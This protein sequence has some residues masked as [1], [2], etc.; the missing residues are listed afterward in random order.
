MFPNFNSLEQNPWK[1]NISLADQHITHPLWNLR[2]YRCPVFTKASNRPYTAL[3][4]YIPHTSV[5][6]FYNIIQL[7]TPKLPC[8]YT[9][10]CWKNLKN[11]TTR[12]STISVLCVSVKLTELLLTQYTTFNSNILYYSLTGSCNPNTMNKVPKPVCVCRTMQTFPPAPPAQRYTWC[13]KSPSTLQSRQ[14]NNNGLHVS[15]LF[16][17]NIPSSVVLYPAWNVSFNICLQWMA[18][19][20][21]RDLT[22]QVS[23]TS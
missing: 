4:E 21:K 8:S 3:Y 10:I 17:F 1:K 5:I 18:K 9:R 13:F 14:K 23:V 22:R 7:P 15:V 11:F 6:F 2:T 20:S 16:V 12:I 19:T